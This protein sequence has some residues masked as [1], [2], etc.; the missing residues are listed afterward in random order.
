QC[1]LCRATCPES[2]ITLR[3]QLDFTDAAR[4]PVTRNE[5]EPFHCIRCGRPFGV[6]ATIERIANQLAGKHHMF[7][8]G[9]QIE[10]IMMCDDCRVVVQFESGND[11]FAGPPRPT[12]RS[13][14]D[15]LR[16]REIE[17][18]RARVRAER[19]A[20]GNGGSDDSRDA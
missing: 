11:P 15:Y 17:E 8:S 12:P 10:R 9:D 16:E 13:T 19:A 18:A 14:D 6:Q 20:R 4:S 7:A 5:Q 1:G 3:P 2:V